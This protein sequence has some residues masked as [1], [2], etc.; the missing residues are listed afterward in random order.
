MH[1]FESKLS[2]C[3][4]L[5]NFTRNVR[6]HVLGAINP[7]VPTQYLTDNMEKYHKTKKS[8]L[9]CIGVE[10]S[11]PL[12]ICLLGFRHGFALSTYALSNLGVVP[13]NQARLQVDLS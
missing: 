2:C 9:E 7:V 5:L 6:K 1:G 8:D 13:P 3:L 10:K 11:N 12:Q 4:N